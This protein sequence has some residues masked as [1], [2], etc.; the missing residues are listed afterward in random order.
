MLKGKRGGGRKRETKKSKTDWKNDKCR[1]VFLELLDDIACDFS[2]EIS[3]EKIGKVHL[4]VW[5]PCSPAA[6]E[7]QCVPCMGNFNMQL[8]DNLL[9]VH[10]WIIE[11]ESIFALQS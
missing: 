1:P 8:S 5:I 3:L 11:N 2:W 6:A 9:Y 10:Q 7:L 4:Q